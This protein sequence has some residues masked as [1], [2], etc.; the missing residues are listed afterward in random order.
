MITRCQL[1]KTAQNLILGHHVQGQNQRLFNFVFK[2]TQTPSTKAKGNMLGVCVIYTTLC[3]PTTA[4][5]SKSASFE[6][7]RSHNRFIRSVQ[8]HT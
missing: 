3:I 1:S 7:K 6:S 4:T 5:H 2:V 8:L